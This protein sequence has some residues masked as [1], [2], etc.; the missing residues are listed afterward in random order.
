MCGIFLQVP[1]II[2]AWQIER[3]AERRT[4]GKTAGVRKGSAAG[5]TS[6]QQTRG[7]VRTGA[8]FRARFSYRKRGKDAPQAGEKA[9]VRFT[10]QKDGRPR[11]RAEGR[12]KGEGAKRRG[13]GSR[14]EVAPAPVLRQ[15]AP[16][17]K[18][19]RTNFCRRADF[20][21]LLQKL[22]KSD[23]T[24]CYSYGAGGKARPPHGR[25]QSAHSSST[26]SYGTR[27]A[28]AR[29]VSYSGGGKVLR[30]QSRNGQNVAAAA[31]QGEEKPCGRDRA[32]TGKTLR[33]S[34]CK[35]RES[36]AGAIERERAKRCGSRIARRGKALRAG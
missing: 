15:T 31:L 13:N 17:E 28:D 11:R 1:R 9:N 14:G 2:K 18:G 3:T 24:F 8:F 22:Q 27:R 30:G 34:H 7:S 29:R 12:R 16:A 21:K 35:E 25:R 26:F 33:R 5:G 6:A 36:L 23:T 32:G 10:G 20:T 4:A 19:R